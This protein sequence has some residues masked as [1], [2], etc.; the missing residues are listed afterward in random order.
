MTKP[1]AGVVADDAAHVIVK[2]LKSQAVL[3]AY[4]AVIGTIALIVAVTR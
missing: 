4:I 2:M 3:L 1:A